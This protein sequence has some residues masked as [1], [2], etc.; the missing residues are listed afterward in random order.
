MKRYLLALSLAACL[1]GL[2]MAQNATALT[3]HQ[4]RER[5]AEQGYLKV[6]DLDFEEGV[7]KA[8][9]RSADGNRVQ[10]RLDPRTGDVYPNEQVARMSERDV[11][12]ALSAAGYTDV[13]D[14]NYRGGI[15]VA[16]ADD[17]GGRDVK[18]KLDPNNGK[19]F[20]VE[21]D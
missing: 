6:N 2:A 18:L 4:I 11:R 7:W 5:L 21:K 12:A 3:E 1:P 14:V 19:I 13:H 17:A 9:A 8:D 10:V 20:G 15:W 16:E